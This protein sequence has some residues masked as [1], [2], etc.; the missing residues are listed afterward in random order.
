MIYMH[1]MR[2]MKN[3]PKSPFAMMEGFGKSEYNITGGRPRVGIGSLERLVS[4]PGLE[5]G[6][7]GLKVRCSTT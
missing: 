1:V 3:A 5:P 4:R 2:K 7:Y 6:T